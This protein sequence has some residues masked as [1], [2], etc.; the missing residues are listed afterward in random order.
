MDRNRF[1]DLARLV[2]GTD[3]RR[4]LIGWLA[5][6][7]LAG[8]LIDILDPAETEAAG[9]RKRRK[10]R[11]KHGKGRRRT[12][13]KHKKK[14]TCTPNCTSKC[15]G[16]N[17]GCGGTCTG[18]CG[19]NQICADQTCQNCDVCA[20]GCTHTIVQAAID[21]ASAGDTIAICPGTYLRS[22]TRKSV[23]TIEKPLTL[24]G[25]G[26]G[27]NGTIFDGR[28]VPN[29]EAVV[30]LGSLSVELRDVTVTGGNAS[31]S[32]SGINTSVQSSLT[33][34][35]V[36]VT[37]NHDNTSGGGIFNNGTLVLNA[38]T[39][40]T[41]NTANDAAAGILNSGTLTLNAGSE[42]TN[43]TTPGIAG[44]IYNGGTV[45]LHPGSKVSG[46]TSGNCINGAGGTGCPPE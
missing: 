26:T 9:R 2:S 27:T 39:A 37:G 17:D 11:H 8:G 40:V 12:N 42:V 13:R 38:G 21:A 16:A 1:E 18:R 41:Y 46:N 31:V 44:G 19:A 20:E 28:G 14:P 3:S 10:K 36:L 22:G 7:S 4:R 35:R 23:A 5:A 33:L 24:I 29:L 45:I 43:N 25:A 32:G 30:F 15:G 34:T 6:T